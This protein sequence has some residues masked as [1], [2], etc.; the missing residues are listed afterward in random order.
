MK[1]INTKIFNKKVKYN[2][3]KFV[4]TINL[5]SNMYYLLIASNCRYWDLLNKTFLKANN[6]ID[7]YNNMFIQLYFY[8]KT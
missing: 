4:L 7:M 3:K 1:D 2:K 8:D 5:K 6:N